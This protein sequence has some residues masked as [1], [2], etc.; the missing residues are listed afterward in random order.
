[1]WR[2]EVALNDDITDALGN[3]VRKQIVEDLH[4][5]VDSVRVID[6]Y[7]INSERFTFDQAETIARDLLTDPITQRYRVEDWPDEE[8]DGLE[9]YHTRVAALI[10]PFDIPFDVAINVGF[11][12]GVTDNVGATTVEGIEDLLGVKFAD[13]ES[14]STSKRYLL[15]GLKDGGSTSADSASGDSVSGIAAHIAKD[16]LANL[17]IETISIDFPK[18]ETE[19]ASSQ[20]FVGASAEKG[21]SFA[22]SVADGKSLTGG[23]PATSASDATGELSASAALKTTPVFAEVDLDVSDEE[24]IEISQKGVLSLNLEEMQ[25]ARGYFKDDKVKAE[26]E[27]I[28]LGA[29][30]TDVELEMIAQTWSEHCKHKIFNATIEYTENGKTET[31]KSLYKTYIRNATAEIDKTKKGWLVSVFVDN[32]G[33]VTFDDDYNMVFKVET[34][35]HPSALDPYGGA[36][37]GIVGVNRDP[38]GTG[39]GANL[40][41]NT[42]VFCFGPPDFSYDN[43][44]GSVLHPK[45]IFK[46]VRR[47][48]QDGGNKI[49]IPTVNGAILF[50]EAYV[51]NPLV[52]CGTGGFMP[53]VIAGKPSHE[54]SVNPGDLIVMAGGR[55]GKDGIHGATFSSVALDEGTSSAAVQ[56][57]AP[58]VQRKMQDAL[59]EARDLGLYNAITD[60]GAGGLSSSVGEMSEFSGGCEVDL[61]KAPVKYPGLL[62]WELWVSESQ[63]RMTAAVPPEKIDEFMDLMRRRDVEA[64]VIG[65]FTDSGKV[66]VKYDGATVLYMNMD[67]LHEGFPGLNLI[68]NWRPEV[69]EVWKKAIAASST[70]SNGKSVD[71]AG[72]AT[73]IL[74]KI[75]G[76]YNVCS[77]EWVIRQYDHEV[78]GQSVVKPLVG[79]QND[80]PSDAAVIRPL[81]DSKR[82]IAVSN[83]INPKYG[84][85]DTYWMA[86]SAIDEA[87]RN[88]VA[89]GGDPDHIA[90]LDNFCWGNPILSDAN[91]DGDHKLAQLVRAAKGCYD[92]AVGMGTPFISGKDSFHNEYKVGDKTVA[93]PPTLL[94]SAMGI[95]PDVEKA[96]TMDAKNAG[97]LVYVLGATYNEFGGSHFGSVI[98]DATVID[99]AAE[100]AAGV[101]AANNSVP[102]MNNETALSLYRALHKAMQEGLVA[103]CHDCSDGGIATAAAETAFAGGL[104]MQIDANRIPVAQRSSGQGDNSDTQSASEAGSEGSNALLTAWQKLF[105]E[106]NS[107][108]VVTV[109][110]Q[111]K[112]AFEK[113]MS[114]TAISDK[115]RNVFAEIGKIT[116]DTRFTIAGDNGANEIDTTIDELKE[117]WISP[118][119]W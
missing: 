44:P 49:G 41:F 32:A 52:Y 63:E 15:S 86:A 101:S 106:S 70:G 46:G 8:H 23:K 6:V 96:V 98:G 94:I 5:D 11:K 47:G 72:S 50:D 43:L 53:K 102:K 84:E 37:T 89:V 1:M 4:I 77:K 87:I 78:Q 75:L 26:R 42:D 57:G 97:D 13:K 3:S 116:A 39:I 111:N 22:G 88:I 83:G 81:I 109:S 9:E 31:I 16:L 58:I 113:A 17:L 67:F 119:R 79:D 61:E 103:S 33:V 112:E 110:P 28:G 115:T 85:I 48:V 38:M 36:I 73:E 34:H 40:I 59:R 10:R 91:P 108:F 107:R 7:S 82:G 104:G 55:I 76:S 21:S 80:G 100:G 51:Y 12:P 90:I 20:F 64:T 95:V 93:I 18:T 19:M 105:S 56:I 114:G 68:A 118:L 74:K 2:I 62:P 54:K 24:L 25:K 69:Q 35:N 30:P 29:K 92:T 45:R 66:H 14:V 27:K 99:T 71:S 65:E 60:N 117:A